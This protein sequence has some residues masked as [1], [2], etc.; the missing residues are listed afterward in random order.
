METE[1][2]PSKSASGAS[3]AGRISWRVLPYQ[4]AQQVSPRS[5]ARGFL[6]EAPAHV[7]RSSYS[8]CWLSFSI[9]VLSSIACIVLRTVS[10]APFAS[11]SAPV[12]ASLTA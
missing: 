3:G 6:S 10:S 2:R 8:H 1:L 11:A 9:Q 7:G 5:L 4:Q 12:S